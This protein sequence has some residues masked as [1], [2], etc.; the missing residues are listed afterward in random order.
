MRK[1]IFCAGEA[2]RYAHEGDAGA[3]VCANEVVTIRCGERAL[4]RTGLRLALP[5]DTVAMV[6]SRSG[7]AH[8]NGIIV[9]NAP[10]IVDS[11]Y[12]GEVMVNLL[13]TGKEDFVV[14]PG[15]RIAQ[16][17]LLPFISGAFMPVIEE[18]FDQLADTE[19]G[20]GGHGSSGE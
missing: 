9:A 1:G 5:D 11:G 17:V 3:D 20:E 15:M 14:R 7:L 10:G 16:L 12:R 4:V 8:K 6:C 18:T 2:P 13:N 19:R